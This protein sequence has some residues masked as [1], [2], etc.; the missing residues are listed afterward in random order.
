[1]D[2]T[3]LL[4]A[5]V[6]A[7][8]ALLLCAMTTAW[9]FEWRSGKGR[10]LV[11][12]ILA[13]LGAAAPSAL[14]AVFPAEASSAWA[15]FP[16]AALA[17]SGLAAIGLAALFLANSEALDRHLEGRPFQ[18]WLLPQAGLGALACWL[19][20]QTGLELRRLAPLPALELASCQDMHVGLSCTPRISLTEL[21]VLRRKGLLDGSM[22]RVGFGEDEAES[23]A[24][25]F[26][27]LRGWTV[28]A[29]SLSPAEVGAHEVELV[30]RHPWVTVR[31]P[32][33]YEA[34]EVSWDP[35]FAPEPG[36]FW[37]YQHYTEVGGERLMLVLRSPPR[38]EDQEPLVIRVTE[39]AELHGLRVRK[40]EVGEQVW[41]LA[42]LEGKTWLVDQETGERQPALSYDEPPIPLGELILG[43]ARVAQELEAHRC[44]LRFLPEWS[45]FCVDE[46]LDAARAL[47]GAAWCGDTDEG[48]RIGATL[49]GL[50][51]LGLVAPRPSQE[52]LVLEASGVTP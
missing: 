18:L 42:G 21:G 27:G 48:S 28:P 24:T 20:A 23:V 39:E 16:E 7:I 46:P 50:A 43:R 38:R 26:A 45:C 19:A 51:T 22:V 5:A 34:H 14:F 49:V 11:L 33:S 9:S 1:M 52:V 37:R 41:W 15:R 32:V 4:P 47:P 36:S 44:A 31:T 3:I 10:S 30:A 2:L 17:A 8:L 25:S 40:L 6:A 29:L 35:R 13:V 12:A